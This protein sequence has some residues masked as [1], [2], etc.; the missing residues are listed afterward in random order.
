[1]EYRKYRKA[2][3]A[4]EMTYFDEAIERVIAGLQKKSRV[5]NPKEKKTVELTASRSNRIRRRRK[6]TSAKQRAF[7]LSLRMLAE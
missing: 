1:M 6:E 5:M 2:K 7:G 4:V 3:N